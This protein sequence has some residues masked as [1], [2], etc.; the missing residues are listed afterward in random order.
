MKFISCFE[1]LYCPS[2]DIRSKSLSKSFKRPIL[3]QNLFNV[4]VLVRG[5]QLSVSVLTVPSELVSEYS[6]LFLESDNKEFAICLPMVLI[7][8]QV[9]YKE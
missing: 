9:L 5:V 8:N 6:C 3:S 1:P 4:P 2:L 7:P